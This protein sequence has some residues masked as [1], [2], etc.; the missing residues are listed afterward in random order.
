MKWIALALIIVGVVLL[1]RAFT[2]DRTSSFD[3]GSFILQI[4]VGGLGAVLIAAGIIVLLAML[5]IAL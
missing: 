2:L 1:I 4:L 3:D 5:F